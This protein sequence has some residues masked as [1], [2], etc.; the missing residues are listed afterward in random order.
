MSDLATECKALLV[1]RYRVI[2]YADADP[3][4]V[5]LPDGLRWMPSWHSNHKAVECRPGSLLQAERIAAMCRD[6]GLHGVIRHVDPV[7]PSNTMRRG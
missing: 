2:V 3:L 5:K 1:S 4:L 6:N 7:P